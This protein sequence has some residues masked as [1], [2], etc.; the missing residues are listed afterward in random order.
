MRSRREELGWA[1]QRLKKPGSAPRPFYR[2]GKLADAN[3]QPAACRSVAHARLPNRVPSGITV[4]E[5]R[6]SRLPPS[7][8]QMDRASEPPVCK[9][10]KPIKGLATRREGA[11]NGDLA[12]T[13]LD[14]PP[15]SDTSAPFLGFHYQRFVSGLGSPVHRPA[16]IPV[17]LGVD[18]FPDL[19]IPGNMLFEV[20][21]TMAHAIEFSK[22]LRD[23]QRNLRPVSDVIE[24][25]GSRIARNPTR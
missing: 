5:A 1:A 4:F 12:R 3:F 20:L 2:L 16:S 9:C 24:F 22:L 15:R 11:C 14:P 18:R 25:P 17:C 8:R 19:G 6:T 10:L 23:H 13:E 7:H 21:R